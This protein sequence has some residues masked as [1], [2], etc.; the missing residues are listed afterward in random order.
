MLATAGD[1]PNAAHTTINNITM[2]SKITPAN[3]KVNHIVNLEETLN[4]IAWR[5]DMRNILKDCGVYGHIE[6]SEKRTA[7]YHMSLKPTEPADDTLDD[8]IAAYQKWWS[9]DDSAK[10][11][12][13]RKVSALVKSNLNAGEDVTAQMVWNQIMTR[14]ARVNIN[15]QFA[16]KERLA[17]IKLKDY[18]EI[19]KYLDKFRTGRERLKDM[20]TIIGSLAKL[21]TADDSALLGYA[22]S[23]QNSNR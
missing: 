17:S 7:R 2:S 20:S 14:Y 1:V 8:V 13:T 12:I 9:N 5:D 22:G 3:A 19:E 4:F 23:R 21:Q 11:L 15:A 18:T 10:T 6:G 16:I